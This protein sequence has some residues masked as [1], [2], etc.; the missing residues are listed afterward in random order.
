MRTLVCAVALGCVAVAGAG[1]ARAVTLPPHFQESEVFGDLVNP[2]A[3]R[4][5]ADGRVFVAEKSGR[6]LVFSTLEDSTPTVFADLSTEVYNFWDRG[7]LGLAL[8]PGFPVTP[9]VYVTYT[10]DAAIG[11]AVPRWGSIGVFSDPCPTPPGSTEDGCVVSGRISRLEANGDV[12]TGAERVLVDDWCQQ[13]PSHSVGDLQFGADGALYVSS[14]EGA[15]FYSED[16]G[17]FGDQFKGGIRNPCG[18]PPGGVG[19]S[20]TPPT[21]EGGSLRSQD[22]RTRSDPT[23]LSGTVI[24]IDPS[25][26]AGMP[27]NP[28]SLDP[29]ANARRIVGFGLRNPFRIAIRPGTSDVWIGD[30]GSGSSEEIDRIEAPADTTPDNFGWPCFEGNYRNGGFESLSLDLCEDLYTDGAVGPVHSYFHWDEVVPGDGC[31]TGTSSISGLTFYAGGDYPGYDGA[32]FFADYSR[33]CIWA[34]RSGDDELPD[35]AQL[36]P[37]VVGAADPVDLEIGPGG[38]LFYVD[39]DGGTVRRVEY[40][41]DNSAPVARIDA[42]PTSGPAP[43]AVEFDATGSTDADGDTLSYM[44]DLD[45]DGSFDDSTEAQPSWTYAVR[46]TYTARLRVGDPDGATNSASVVVHASNSVPVPTIE[47]PL[48]GTEW[49][50]G[51]RID[52]AGSAQDLEE[53]ALPPSHLE[54][55]LLLHHCP[56]G[57]HVHVVQLYE[58][59][60]A[61]S[62]VAPDHSYPS[63]L[64]LELTATDSDGASATTSRLLDPR[65]VLLTFATSPDGLRLVAAS[66]ESTAPFAR[67]VIVGSRITVTAPSPQSVFGTPF[68]FS[69]WSDGGARSHE[70]VAPAAPANYMATFVPPPPPPAPTPPPPPA[71]QPPPLLPPPPPPPPSRPVVVVRCVV[72]GVKGRTLLR[73]RR[74]IVAARCSVGRVTR[75]YSG[76]VRSGYVLAQ[77]PRARTRLPTGAKVKIVVSRGRRR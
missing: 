23:G 21:A 41:G 25:T 50:V 39:F 29:E 9:Y 71:P 61:G 14:G 77:S 35:P 4:F 47:S 53:D 75:A 58:G 73:A 6:I 16:Y 66:S 36:Q 13:F 11:G 46:G 22:L 59:V 55:R 17:Q 76:T 28:L 65:T 42:H 68:S 67:R 38:D 51:D 30:V 2:T 70:L 45:G 63:H 62:F 3:V 8:D 24:R 43:L 72:P 20:Q 26:G 40:L 5:A 56:A 74:A 64:E 54:W 10:R 49:S 31:P 27:D 34:M 48:V 44:W 52:F 18:D 12:M 37:F 32:L 19:G 15:H 7:L 69:S 33:R 60:E 1:G 57:C